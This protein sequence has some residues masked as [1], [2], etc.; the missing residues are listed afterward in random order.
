MRRETLDRILIKGKRISMTLD[1]T[2]SGSQ[3]DFM[4]PYLRKCQNSES[5]RGEGSTV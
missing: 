2:H 3:D 4:R 1:P 5:L